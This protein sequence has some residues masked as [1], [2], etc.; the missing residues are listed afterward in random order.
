MYINLFVQRKLKYIMRGTQIPLRVANQQ[1]S[2]QRIMMFLY[3]QKQ[4][5]GA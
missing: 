3:F 2:T 1:N 5:V 4:T